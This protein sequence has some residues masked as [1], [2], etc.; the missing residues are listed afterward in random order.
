MSD[1]TLKAEIKSSPKIVKFDN[2]LIELYSF[3]L[4]M[5]DPQ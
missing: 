2:L 5:E 1:Y 3:Q 4:G